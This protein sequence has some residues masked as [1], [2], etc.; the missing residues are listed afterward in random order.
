M[1][2]TFSVSSCSRSLMWPARADRERMLRISSVVWLDSWPSS[3]GSPAMRRIEFDSPL[4]ATMKG[5]KTQANP[6]RKP[7]ARN[8]VPSARRRAHIFGACSPTVMCRVVISVKA[9]VIDTTG[10]QDDAGSNGIPAPSAAARI[11]TETAGS[12]SAPSTRLARV[13]P[14][15]HADR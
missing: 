9:M 15:W 12:P 10:S 6:R 2:N 14:S 11:S 7:A 4:M 13:I 8:A 1:R 5:P 3:A